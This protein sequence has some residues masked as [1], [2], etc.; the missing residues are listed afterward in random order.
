MTEIN[1]QQLEKEILEL[2]EKIG[3]A[4]DTVAR[5]TGVLGQ[6]NKNLSELGCS[7]VAEAAE[8]IKVLEQREVTLTKKIQEQY[9]DI[10]T[11]LLTPSPDA[12]PAPLAP[13]G[14]GQ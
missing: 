14:L 10:Q 7:S 3:T 1:S 5:E 11:K 4:R 2:N 8:K 9:A 6:L 12:H 13:P